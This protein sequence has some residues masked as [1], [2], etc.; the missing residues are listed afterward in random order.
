MERSYEKIRRVDLERLAALADRDRED[1]FHRNPGTASLYEDRVLCVTLAQGAALHYVDGK[2]GVKDF[3][4]W[5][6]YRTHP[7]RPFPYRR[8]GVVDFGDPRFGLS[9]DSPSVFTGKR[10]DLIGRSIDVRRNESPVDAVRRYLHSGRTMSAR[11]LAQKAMIGLGP[12]E[13]FGM[14][15]WP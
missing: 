1:F 10:V 13:L 7:E 8:R 9:P 3:D 4:V 11:L 12:E 5:S 2:T 6:F 15:I 14:V